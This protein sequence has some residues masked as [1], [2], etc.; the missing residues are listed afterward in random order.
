MK[1]AATMLKFDWRDVDGAVIQAVRTESVRRL[2][3]GSETCSQIAFVLADKAVVLSVD[4]DT[5]QIVV[6]LKPIGY[7]T[8]WLALGSLQKL[9]ARK[10]GWCWAA[11]NSQGYLDIFILAVDGV[12]PAYIFTAVASDLQCAQVRQLTD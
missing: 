3:D 2:D 7:T 4:A 8:D 9:V 12:D 6:T 1:K 10:L 11:R 5:D